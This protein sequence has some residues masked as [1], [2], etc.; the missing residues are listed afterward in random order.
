MIGALLYLRLTSLRNLVVHRPPQAAPAEVPDR[1]RR[2]GA[3][4]YFFLL[5]RASGAGAAAPRD[6]R[7]RAPSSWR[8]RLRGMC[9]SALVRI[10][11]AWIAPAE[12][13]GLRFSEAEIAFLFPA[14]ITRKALIHFRLLSTQLAILFTSVLIAVVFNRFGY[15]GGEPRD[16]ARGLVGHPLDIRPPPE[17]D[18]PDARPPEGTRSA[19]FLLWR[20]AAVAAIASTRRG[21]WSAMGPREAV[22]VGRRA[23]AGRGPPRSCASSWP[24]RRSTGS[25]CRSGSSSPPYFAR[26]ARRFAL[27][28]VPALA[29]LAL[30]YLWVSST[31]A[32]FEEGSIALAEKRAAIRAAAL[33]GEAPRIGAARKGPPG[34]FPLAPPA[35][36]DR[37]PLEEPALDAQL[38]LEPQ[39]A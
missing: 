38:P 30:H 7:P 32:R 27:A 21:V 10:A 12:K 35:A 4:F 17:R 11:F 5:R 3:Y 15:L 24:R 36:G 2:R 14:P 28:I 6:R 18:Q 26:A 22:F 20:A 23:A 19:H 39:D 16:P 37:V 33:R 1:H 13:P 34:P 31:E 29:V 9:A 8:L 25:S